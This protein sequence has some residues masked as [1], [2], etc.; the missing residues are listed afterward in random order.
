MTDKSGARWIEE[1][2]NEESSQILSAS[3]ARTS[4]TLGASSTS[5]SDKRSRG[6]IF[7]H[8]KEIFEKNGE[9][10]SWNKILFKAADLYGKQRNSRRQNEITNGC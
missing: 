2:C 5:T 8:P 6:L 10:L 4:E 9:K 3:T 1:R 7:Y